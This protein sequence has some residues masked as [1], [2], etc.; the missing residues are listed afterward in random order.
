MGYS[1]ILMI[2]ALYI[3]LFTGVVIA[4][5]MGPAGIE[6]VRWTI[7]KGLKQGIF[8][9]IGVLIADAFDIMLI[10]FGLLD[11]IETDKILEIIFWL[12]SGS[13]IFYM[14]HREIRKSKSNKSEKEKVPLEEKEI[15]S[16]P[17]LK[18]FIINFTNPMTH[19]FWLTL[20]STVIRNWR[21][22]GRLPYFIFSVSML[23]GMF[24]S[25]CS[26]N[27]LAHKGKRINT[28]K[29]SGKL[30]SLLAYGIAIIG[31]GFFSYGLYKLYLLTSSNLP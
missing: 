18:G 26:I 6:S 5:P 4:I 7:T 15:K 10:N 2:R 14:G 22:A 31:I 12:L 28:P 25:L 21:Y 1:Y 24:L 17:I 9:V 3:G 20:S 23:C 11:L 27:F 13:I 8:V 16:L 30:N 29:L 19:S